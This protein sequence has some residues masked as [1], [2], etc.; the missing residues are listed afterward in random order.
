MIAQIQPILWHNH[1]SIC[2]RKHKTPF[3]RLAVT[4]GVYHG[5][6]EGETPNTGLCE[7]SVKKKSYSQ[8]HH[9]EDSYGRFAIFPA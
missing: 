9:Q 5:S 1:C 7:I 8:K 3:L 2:F 4:F 6:R